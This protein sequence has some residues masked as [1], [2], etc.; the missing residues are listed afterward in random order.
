MESP[1]FLSDFSGAAEYQRELERQAKNIA[2]KRQA[3]AVA[4][5]LEGIDAEDENKISC[6]LGIL[7]YCCFSVETVMTRKA[8]W[9]ADNR[10][11]MVSMGKFPSQW[12]TTISEGILDKAFGLHVQTLPYLLWILLR[13]I[14]RRIYEKFYGIGDA[15]NFD[16]GPDRLFVLCSIIQMF[17]IGFFDGF[18]PLKEI[19]DDFM[20][21]MY[22]YIIWRLNLVPIV[23]WGLVW[24]VSGAR[25][26]LV[27]TSI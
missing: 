19:H 17:N 21:K 4:Y 8:T 1:T 23:V 5:H 13:M 9:M 12:I 15:L 7:E 22:D 24:F 27:R 20:V 10:S 25:N 6:D 14:K 2:K 18:L 26:W 3:E 16:A 11:Q